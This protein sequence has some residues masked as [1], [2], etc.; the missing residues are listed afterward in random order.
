MSSIPNLPTPW[1]SLLVQPRP[2]E[3]PIV[4]EGFLRL[5]AWKRS[6]ASIVYCVR[7]FEHWLSPQGWLR[8]WLRINVLAAVLIGTSALLLGPVV[9]ALLVSLF[10]WTNISVNI[11]V[12][13]MS[14]VA[15]LPP[16]LLAIV[17]GVFLWNIIRRRRGPRRNQH[18]NPQFYE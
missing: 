9:T 5:P 17:S 8:Q 1:Q 2:V 11:V 14:M 13:I 12:K 18:P 3:R 7:K 6:V 16:V 15:I 10:D 4:D